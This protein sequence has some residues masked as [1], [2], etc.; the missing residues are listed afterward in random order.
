[1][2]K[3]FSALCLLLVSA[4]LAVAAP[5]GTITKVSSSSVTVHWGSAAA[6]SKHGMAEA[7]TGHSREYTFTVTPSTVITVHGTKA[8]LGSLQKGMTVNVAHQGL[9]ATRLDVP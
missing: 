5:P 6:V 8:S 2:K 3:L 9:T 7:Y 4:A 1:M